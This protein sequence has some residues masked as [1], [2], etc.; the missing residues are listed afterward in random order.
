MAAVIEVVVAVGDE[1]GGHQYDQWAGAWRTTDDVDDASA[2]DAPMVWQVGLATSHSAEH[3]GQTL[4]AEYVATPSSSIRACSAVRRA[5]GAAPDY[6]A[7][8]HLRGDQ[9]RADATGNASLVAICS[10]F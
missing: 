9:T 4:E 2:I 5:P 3:T 10:S 8:N 6:A 7:R 1:E